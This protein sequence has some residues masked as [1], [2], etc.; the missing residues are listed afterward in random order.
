M[1]LQQCQNEAAHRVLMSQS[2][3]PHVPQ[4]DE[5]ERRRYNLE[6][7]PK[8]VHPSVDPREHLVLK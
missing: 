2:N 3:V 5:Q 1:A 4:V 7:H 6:H 8:T